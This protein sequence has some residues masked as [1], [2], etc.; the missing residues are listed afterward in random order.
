MDISNTNIS[1]LDKKALEATIQESPG[2]F[3]S[4]LSPEDIDAQAHIVAALQAEQEECPLL[5]PSEESLR[6]FRDKLDHER[7]QLE[8]RK[9]LE[10]TP[11]KVAIQDWLT[12][13][14][15]GTRKNYAYYMQDMIKR[16]IIPEKEPNGNDF[17][18]GHFRHVPHELVI[19]YIKK[20]EDWSEGTRQLHAAV[21]IS[22]TAYLDRISQGWVRKVQPSTLAANP[23][24]FQIREKCSTEALTLSDWNR[25]IDA[26]TDINERDSLIARA[27]LHGAKRI[28]EVITITL[29]QIDWDKNIIRFKQSKTG[30]TFREIPITY[31]KYFM[32]ELQKYIEDTSPIRKDSPYVFITRNGNVVTRLRLN[33][34][35]AQAG[36]KAKIKIKVTPH[37][38]RATWVTL[39]KQ[40]NVSDSEIMQITGHR[41][42][43]MV[44]AYDKT[45]DEENVS[46]RLSFI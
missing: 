35:F 11:I 44:M 5:K 22:F 13:L 15:S 7:T 2:A 6:F 18:V 25:F 32:I 20:V 30:S 4:T 38:L 17:T 24:F 45:S 34:S 39:V 28:S 14:A 12:N 33:Y 9:Q 21:Y 1:P 29:T 31:P 23:T 36:K 3:C 26:L 16:N 46:K 43:K 27:L 8:Y 19:D 10:Y 37:V 42:N 41:S 40:Q